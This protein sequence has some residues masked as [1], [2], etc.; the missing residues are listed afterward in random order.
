MTTTIVV[1]EA[2]MEMVRRMVEVEGRW[3]AA[4]D[5][6]HADREMFFRLGLGLE[7]YD[8]PSPQP[9]RELAYELSP[10]IAQLLKTGLSHDELATLSHQVAKGQFASQ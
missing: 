3:Q 7:G 10:I 6:Y 2:Q 5:E 1:N 9:M 8:L 4:Y